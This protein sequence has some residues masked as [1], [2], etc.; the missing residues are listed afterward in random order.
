MLSY[1][2]KMFLDTFMNYLK[3][4]NDRMYT[5]YALYYALSNYGK[6]P[7]GVFV[8]II[9]GNIAIYFTVWFNIF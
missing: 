5:Y 1:D 8:F 3:S 9:I 4:K 6:Y 7:N 2:L